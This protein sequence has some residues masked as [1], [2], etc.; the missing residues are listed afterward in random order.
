MLAFCGQ[1]KCSLDGN[2]RVKISPRL[3]NDFAE[4]GG[5]DVVLYCLPEGAVAVYPLD[6]YAQMRTSHENA[7]AKAGTSMLARRSLRRFGALSHPQ[8]ITNQGRI[9][10]PPAY[11]GHAGL[12]PGADVVIVGIEI[13]IEIW[14]AS[15]WEQ[16]LSAI[17]EHVMQKAELEIAEDLNGF[18]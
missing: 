18:E 15:R 8:S 12:Q 5:F 7:A 4:N 14:E 1:D 17:N 6:V 2:G 13:G 9:T 3:L 10:L 16:E 11:R